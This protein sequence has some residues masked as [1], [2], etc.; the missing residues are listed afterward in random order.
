MCTFA[1]EDLEMLITGD[2]SLPIYEGEIEYFDI[3][4]KER[5]VTFDFVH[6]KNES[7]ARKRLCRVHGQTADILSIGIES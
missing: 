7:D 3:L 1:C 2:K 4:H 6:A 5:A